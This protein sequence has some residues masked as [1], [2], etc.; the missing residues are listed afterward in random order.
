[1]KHGVL[2]G[3]AVILS[4]AL[5]GCGGAASVPIEGTN[6]ANDA[7]PTA[8][9]TEN[10]RA[11][12]QWH[13]DDGSPSQGGDAGANG[14]AAASFDPGRHRRV[15]RCEHDGCLGKHRRQPASRRRLQRLVR[16]KKR[17]RRAPTKAR[18]PTT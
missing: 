7:G 4:M 15:G 3:H 9:Q 10:R 5:V 17:R 14:D 8:N 1:M 2:N 11:S 13:H 16:K 12:R 18:P 6:P